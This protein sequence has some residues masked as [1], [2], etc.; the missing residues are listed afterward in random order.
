MKF[1]IHTDN[2]HLEGTMSQTFYIG[3]VFD[4]KRKVLKPILTF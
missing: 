4:I 1:H 3:P 2:I